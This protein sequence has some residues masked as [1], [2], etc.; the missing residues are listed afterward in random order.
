MGNRQTTT[1]QSKVLLKGPQ[2]FS[3]VQGKE[4]QR[5]LLVRLGHEG[6]QTGLESTVS[7]DAIS[8]QVRNARLTWAVGARAR[9]TVNVDAEWGGWEGAGTRVVYV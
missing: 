2:E 3:D 4:N 5:L 1:E 9:C 7:A 6:S 8:L